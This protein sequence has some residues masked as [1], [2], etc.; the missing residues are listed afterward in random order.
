MRCVYRAAWVVSRKR[1]RDGQ[2][3][4]RGRGTQGRAPIRGAE[5]PVRGAGD[6][7]C[8]AGDAVCGAGDAVHE[9]AAAALPLTQPLQGHG[10][11]GPMLV[12]APASGSLPAGSRPVARACGCARHGS[13]AGQKQPGKLCR[14]RRRPGDQAEHGDQGDHG[15][16]CSRPAAGAAGHG[17]APG[18]SPCVAPASR[19]LMTGR[20]TGRGTGRR[21][22]RRTRE[23]AA[24]SPARRPI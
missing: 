16:R 2:Q 3:R 9:A 6:A 10:R 22:G 1:A 19:G 4:I 7:V 14:T 20:G 5:D 18:W 12:L 17:T 13:A 23:A 24:C 8:G 11:L 21:T 15:G